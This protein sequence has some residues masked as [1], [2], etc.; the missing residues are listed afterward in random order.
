MSERSAP[1]DHPERAR[2]RVTAAA[3]GACAQGYVSELAAKSPMELTHLFEQISGSDEYKEEY[4]RLEREKKKADEDQIYN[5]QKKK[6]LAQERSNAAGPG[7]NATA[8]SAG[9][10]AR[11][12]PL[13]PFSCSRCAASMR[14][15]KEE[16]EKYTELID[17][18]K[19]LQQRT[20]DGDRTCAVAAV[21]TY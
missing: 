1:A 11:W 8:P 18:R 16:A 6:G 4:E 15:Q 21:T 9:V 20:R 3:L 14:K 12:P 13:M 10:Q 17:T 19:E 5:Y 7:T 2:A